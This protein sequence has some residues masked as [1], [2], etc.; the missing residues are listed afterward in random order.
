MKKLIASLLAGVVAIAA[1]TGVASAAVLDKTVPSGTAVVRTSCEAAY[2]VEI[3]ADM[4]IPF[5]APRTQVGVVRAELM[6][7]E[8][9]KAVY[10]DIASNNQYHLVNA[11]DAAHKIP[12]VL[13]GDQGIV[14]DEINDSTLF[15]LTVS[16]TPESWASAYAGEHRD[17][18]VFT[19]SYR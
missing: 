16:V 6:K 3:P 14:F 2:R 11:G 4:E 12:F 1:C 8:P 19:I 10:V 9:G 18:L 13:G 17:T 7:I 5:D 15:P